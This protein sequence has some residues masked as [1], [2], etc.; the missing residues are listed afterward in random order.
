MNLCQLLAHTAERFKDK[1][2]LDLEGD[3]QTFGRLFDQVAR[4]ASA[5]GALGVRPGDRVALQLPKSAAFIH[6]H[7]AGLCLGA[8]SLPLNPGYRTEEVAYFLDDAGARLFITDSLLNSSHGTAVERPGRRTAL[9]DGSG[10]P[11]AV[12]LHQHLEDRKGAPLSIHPA[13]ADDP[14]VI[15]YTSGTTGRSKGAVISHGNLVE[16]MLALQQTWRWTEQDILLHILPLFHVHGLM[17]ALHGSLNAGATCVMHKKFDPGRTWRTLARRRCTLLMGVPTMY[18]RLV[19]Q[20]PGLSPAP[21][22]SAMRVFISGSA[23]LPDRLF[24]TFEQLTGYRILERYGMTETGMI[25]SNPYDPRER[26]PGSVGYPL[27]GVEVRV[28]DESGRDLPPGEVGQVLVRGPNVFAGYWGRPDQTAAA[29]SGGWFHTGDLGF[30]DPED[31]LR[32]FLKGRAKELIISGGF[33][34]YPKEVEAAID[35]HPAVQESAVVGLSDED[36]GERVAAAVVLK[37]GQARPGS[38]EIILH[39]KGKLASYKCPKQVVFLPELPRNAMG[40]VQKSRIVE[41]LD[42]EIG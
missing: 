12:D 37:K 6:W 13:K 5:L 2:A 29:F 3:T 19:N 28:A 26:K 20:W 23:P 22:L 34:V 21:D 32:L 1:T 30:L 33:N 15:C 18:Q 40:K 4:H 14:A 16:N 35:G 31:S 11:G 41:A 39:C 17:V 10:P 42:T 9:V 8:V 7:L 24:N 25:A 38:E 36:L 27:P